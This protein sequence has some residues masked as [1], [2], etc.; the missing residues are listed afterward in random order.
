MD[1]A[2]YEA[3]LVEKYSDFF[4]NNYINHLSHVGNMLLDAT[5]KMISIMLYFSK[6]GEVENL[7]LAL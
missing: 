5:T 2:H 6:K 7:P 1:L 4:G 3:F